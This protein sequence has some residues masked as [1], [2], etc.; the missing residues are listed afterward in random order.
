MNSFYAY[1][2]REGAGYGCF[3]AQYKTILEFLV[4]KCKHCTKIFIQILIL[5]AKMK[6]VGTSEPKK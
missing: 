4:N 5:K 3:V 2:T 1:V 6:D